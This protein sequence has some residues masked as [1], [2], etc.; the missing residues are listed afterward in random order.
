LGLNIVTFGLWFIWSF[1][2]YTSLRWFDERST[3]KLAA[4][5]DLQKHEINPTIT[6]LA[7]RVGLKNAFRAS[8]LV[9]GSC[10]AMVDAFINQIHTF[11]VPILA[12]IVGFDHV[13][14]AAHNNRL[15]YT[16]EKIGVEEFENEHE[17]SMHELARFGWW[18]R[19][20]L[21]SKSEP[22]AILMLILA[23]P[24]VATLGYAMLATE[25]FTIIAFPEKLLFIPLNIA[26]CFV[27]ALVFIQPAPALGLLILSSRYAH[28]PHG[29]RR[30]R[31]SRG[32]ET[33][34]L[35]LPI[36]VVAEALAAARR[37]SADVVKME[38]PI[39]P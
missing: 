3:A 35:E 17:L 21:I 9:I 20:R 34:R 38:I 10:V 2:V 13:L 23:A 8:W 30:S 4:R 6:W 22:A 18:Q 33:I 14:A 15:S 5:I 1:S 28:Q 19:I 27:I 16:V 7:R 31:N 12:L 24:L 39:S 26:L 11:G 36:K 37:E 32:V 29:Q 25:A